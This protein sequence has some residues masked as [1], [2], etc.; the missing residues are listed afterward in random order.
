MDTNIVSTISGVL[1][2]LFAI[3]AFWIGRQSLKHDLQYESAYQTTVMFQTIGMV[4]HDSSE[5]E[6][7]EKV[8]IGLHYRGFEPLRDI[9]FCLLFEDGYYWRIGGDV[10]LAPGEEVGPKYLEIPRS[11]L[12]GLRLHVSWPTPH[13]STHRKGLRYQA[14]RVNL[15]HELE[16]WRWG[17]FEG[18]R[19]RFHLPL[20]KWR[21][22]KNPP[23]DPKSLT[24]WPHG[25]AAKTIDW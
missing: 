7:K 1:S 17:H 25:R 15:N 9:R 2:T 10:T 24:N 4:R 12:E 16:E 20:G 18:L 19:R 11:A 13:P 3:L 23:V 14:V 8:S 21:T 6:P 5:P 22:V